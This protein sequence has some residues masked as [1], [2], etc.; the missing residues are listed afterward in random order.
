[1]SGQGTTT[2]DVERK[3]CGVRAAYLML[4]LRGWNG[5]YKEVEKHIPV[6][7][8][9]SSM[10]DMQAA[11]RELGVSV[12]SASCLPEQVCEL[13]LPAIALIEEA[14]EVRHYVVVTDVDEFEVVFLE[15]SSVTEQRLPRAH[16]TQM[17]TGCYLIEVSRLQNAVER[18]AVFS[19]GAFI[20]VVSL[21]FYIR[22]RRRNRVPPGVAMLFCGVSVLFLSCDGCSPV[23]SETSITQA[24]NAIEIPRDFVQV[25]II[26]RG[27]NVEYTFP[28]RNVSKSPANVQL[29]RPSCGCLRVELSP[30]DGGLAAGHEG[31]IFLVLNVGDRDNAGLMEAKVP[32]FV[33]ES[34]EVHFVTLRGLTEG[35]A[36]YGQPYVIRRGHLE[37]NSIPPV[38]FLFFTKDRNSPFEIVSVTTHVGASHRLTSDSPQASSP[39][40]TL[41]GQGPPIR[42]L[43]VITDKISIG[44]PQPYQGA[45]Y[46][47]EITI[48]V[49][50]SGPV[51]SID[52]HFAVTYRI[53]EES[54][55]IGKVDLL[56]LAGDEK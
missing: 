33:R 35:L 40:E 3:T 27:A 38:K 31:T 54:P 41:V 32:L 11:M 46:L 4:R 21:V 22:R 1:L 52:G 13:P 28:F 20:V 9:G 19:F 8:S 50:I 12:C 48:P 7:P 23:E 49:S 14:G 43:Q 2:P 53:R 37:K 30:K 24:K 6:G 10:A 5:E 26:Q 18:V 25:D 16:F 47:R 51:D 55:R 45:L 36:N 56:L 15:P 44:T 39:R 29:G 17:S 42:S 34:D